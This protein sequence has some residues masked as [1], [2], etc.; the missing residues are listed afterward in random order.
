MKTL[1][2]ALA[3]ASAVSAMAQSEFQKPPYYTGEPTT[4][5]K[6]LLHGV[7]DYLQDGPRYGI[8][9]VFPGAEN[10]ITNHFTNSIVLI[11]TSTALTNCFLQ[12]GSPTNRERYAMDVITGNATVVLT[13]SNIVVGTTAVTNAGSGF[14]SLTNLY[15]LTYTLPTNSTA[16]VISTGTNWFVLP[17]R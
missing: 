15:A 4:F 14:E 10:I 6:R 5:E 3:L 13:T 16:R 11:R 1:L 17:G 2:I 7:I 9:K 12:M 8:R